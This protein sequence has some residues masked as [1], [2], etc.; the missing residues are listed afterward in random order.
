MIDRYGRNIHYLRLS[1]TERCDLA[2]LY[3]RTAVNCAPAADE[4]SAE[5]FL[6]IVRQMAALG[7]DKV[8]LTGGEPLLYGELLP[9]VKGIAETNGIRELSLTTNG[10]GLNEL[11]FPLKEAGLTRLNVSLDSLQADCYR[12]MSGGAELQKALT[13]LDKALSAGFRPIKLNVVLIKGLNDGE[14]GDFLEL[15]RSGDFFVRFIEYMPI[16]G[17][18]YAERRVCGG[19]ILA[20]YPQ[21]VPVAPAYKG[22]PA[23][24]YALPDH[25]GQVGLIDPI[26]RPFCSDCNRI[27]VTADGMLK[28]CLGSDTEI[29]LRDCLGKGDEAELARRLSAG[30]FNKPAGHHF[31]TDAPKRRTMNRIGG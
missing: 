9:L 1:L 7:I 31:D 21:L 4:L 14:I 5:A 18:A 22:Q 12:K 10:R 24:A 17:D 11:A 19:E 6:S 30:I 13:G 29:P 27:R 20:A 15:T 23:L 8:R 26:T 28:P 25:K 16:G 3:C 2:C